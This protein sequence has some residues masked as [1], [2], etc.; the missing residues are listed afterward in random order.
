MRVLAGLIAVC[1]L[2]GCE[3][4]Q[5]MQR[6]A[7]VALYNSATLV[8]P[9]VGTA[10]LRNACADQLSAS[11]NRARALRP[12]REPFGHFGVIYAKTRT[13]SNGVPTCSYSI[14]WNG[15]SIEEMAPLIKRNCDALDEGEAPCR[16]VYVIEPEGYDPALGASFSESTTRDMVRAFGDTGYGA[17]AVSVGGEETLISGAFSRADADARALQGCRGEAPIEGRNGGAEEVE[18]I[19][20]SCTVVYRFGADAP[21]ASFEVQ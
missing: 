9:I 3:T 13:G 8:T 2:A 18:R 7:Q 4:T 16:R 15:S 5:I 17:V 21:D 20:Q 12:P 19:V 14:G 6:P 11:I 1:A 10:A